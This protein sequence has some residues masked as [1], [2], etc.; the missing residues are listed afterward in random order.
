MFESNHL[1]RFIAMNFL[2]LLT[3]PVLVGLLGV[4]LGQNELYVPLVLTFLA[5]AIVPEIV[6]GFTIFFS[7]PATERRRT[8]QAIATE[9]ASTNQK[10]WT[11]VVFINATT[12]ITTLVV[13]LVESFE[14]EQVNSASGFTKLLGM[15][16]DAPTSKFFWWHQSFLFVIIVMAL[17]VVWLGARML[18]RPEADTTP[19]WA[20][21]AFSYALV[22]SV[23]LFGTPWRTVPLE[24]ALVSS[25]T[26]TGL[27]IITIVAL[28]VFVLAF[29]VLMA[30]AVS[31]LSRTLKEVIAILRRIMGSERIVATLSLVRSIA[32]GA[33]IGAVAFL[34]VQFVIGS[35][36]A[37]S[38]DPG[39]PEEAAVLERSAER[40][41]LVWQD[42]WSFAAYLVGA[43]LAPI[44][45]YLLVKILIWLALRSIELVSFILLTIAS[46]VW[47]AGV[48]LYR[49]LQN[50]NILGIDWN[51]VARW[52]H[53]GTINR[54][55]PNVSARQASLFILALSILN[56]IAVDSIRERQSNSNNSFYA[57]LE[58]ARD[59]FNIPVSVAV[60]PFGVPTP[61]SVNLCSDLSVPPSWRLESTTR[62]EFP[63]AG[64]VLTDDW[65]S[66]NGVLLIYGIA[67]LGGTP[68]DELQRAKRRALALAQN[69]HAQTALSLR[70]LVLNLG[71]AKDE[72][73][74]VYGSRL[75][76]P[77]ADDR[78]ILATLFEPEPLDWRMSD[79]DVRNVINEYSIQSDF[80]RWFSA[81]ELYEFDRTN[82]ELVA[83]DGFECE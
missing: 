8:K 9:E 77:S 15:F 81:C 45:A 54:L 60:T 75:F 25:A 42:T 61:R 16:F 55:V 78:P 17:I 7:Q 31:G 4:A 10:A 63:V 5:A 82:R 83:I 48:W 11:A 44:I 35:I 32:V 53:W 1:T 80:S 26:S 12:S 59:Y 21:G 76:R 39:S 64:C 30:F 79:E 22:L 3:G 41:V 28:L 24:E 62:L 33:A 70:I 49:T 2:A 46:V 58:L 18:A 29:S 27:V 65:V 6:A 14:Q 20:L 51:R 69:T 71:M 34:S 74:F 47:G 19:S 72:Y 66:S 36:A 13:L 73:S 40:I 56:A 57:A 50:Q 43:A 23:V 38:L 67:S 37:I 52:R 68:E